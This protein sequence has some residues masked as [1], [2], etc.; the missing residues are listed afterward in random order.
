VGKSKKQKLKTNKRMLNMKKVKPT[1]EMLRSAFERLLRIRYIQSKLREE[2]EECKEL[3]LQYADLFILKNKANAI[4][5][6]QQQGIKAM[7]SVAERAQYEYPEEI[8]KLEDKLKKM[9]KEAEQNGTAKIVGITRYLA[10]RFEK[11]R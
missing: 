11:N 3:A 5:E 8:K 2:E 10:F 4:V 1:E 9:K 7:V 6:D